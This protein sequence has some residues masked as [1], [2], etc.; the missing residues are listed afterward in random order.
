MDSKIKLYINTVKYLQPLQIYYRPI[1]RA[2]RI[3]YKRNPT[4]IQIPSELNVIDNFNYLITELDFDQEYLNRFDLKAILDDEFT[5]IN[6]TNKVNISQAWNSEELQQLWRYN[7][8]YF[9]YLFKLAYEYSKDNIQYQYYDKFKYLIENWIDNNPFALGDGWHPYTISLRLT[10]WISVYPVFKDRIKADIEFDRKIKESIYLQYLYLQKNLEKDVL[11]NHYFEN[12][13]ALIIGSFFFA[14]EKVKYKFKAELIKQLDEQ[15]LQDGMHFEL[16]PM[17]HKII[18]EDL[19]KITYWL[20]DDS[21]YS[22]LITYIQKMITVTNSIEENFGKT[23]AFND[24]ADGISKG[25]KA[26]MRTC[27]KYFNLKPEYNGNLEV[28]GFYIINDQ[29][30]KL[31]FDTGEICPKYLPAHGHCD[32]LSF[33]LSVNNKPL[34]VNSGT[35]RYENGE[36]RN[37]FRS[38]KSHN[39][40]TIE[41]QEQSQ[42][43][44]SFRIAGRIKKVRRKSFDYKGIPFYAGA[45]ISFKG[46]EHKRF[47]GFINEKLIIVLD[48]V[49]KVLKAESYLH[50]IPE[51]KLSISNSTVNVTYENEKIKI[52]TI[53]T[54]DIVLKQGWYSERFNLKEKN[55]GLV[56]KKDVSEG[57]FG[58]LIDLGSSNG[59]IYEKENEIKIIGDKEII[60]NLNRLGDML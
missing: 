45:Y 58:Y 39:T 27:E 14:E 42:F 47:I 19:I 12:I 17:Y 34:I 43:W 36:W 2:K 56:F 21:I 22:Q 1:N 35:F 54:S 29:Y 60:I 31:I 10:N 38:T 50:F 25:R 9:E 11:G 46:N 33:E 51:A 44:G 24:S 16:S 59:E 3:L 53:G 32:A 48:F 30:K 5:F 26:L 41:D 4:R 40:V 55:N 37:Y 28:S 52:I 8:H 18:L 7:L 23:P 20:I 49:E 6:I 57:Y 15:V 13:K